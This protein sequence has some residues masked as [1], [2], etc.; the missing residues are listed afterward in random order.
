MEE[1]PQRRCPDISLARRVLHWEPLVELDEGLR[2]T[3]EWFARVVEGAGER[4]SSMT[5]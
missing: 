4:P 1:D 2:R 5:L 3:I